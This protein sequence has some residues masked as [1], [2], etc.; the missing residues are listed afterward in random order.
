MAAPAREG[1][2]RRRATGRSG[3]EGKHRVAD[4]VDRGLEPGQQQQH[5]QRHQFIRRQLVGILG[6]QVAHDVV[7]GLLAAIVERLRED[8]SKPT[9]RLDQPSHVGG[10]CGPLSPLPIVAP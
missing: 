8:P 3:E 1:S 2:E 7:T 5:A 6:Q 9:V 4:Q 10:D